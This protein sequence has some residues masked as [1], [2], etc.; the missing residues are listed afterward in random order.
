MRTFFEIFGTIVWTMLNV[1]GWYKVL[2]FLTPSIESLEFFKF[3]SYFCA[4]PV[5]FLIGMF[6]W[7]LG[8]GV[9]FGNSRA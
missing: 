4:I 8:M 7:W 6:F 5:L 9:I 1:F 3:L 2:T